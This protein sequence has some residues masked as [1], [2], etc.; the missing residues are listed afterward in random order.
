MLS[1]VLCFNFVIKVP[2]VIQLGN[3]FFLNIQDMIREYYL[4]IWLRA[5]ILITTKTEKNCIIY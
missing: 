3:V 4:K 5:Y 2:S 1:L